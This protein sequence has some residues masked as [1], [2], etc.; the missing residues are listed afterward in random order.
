MIVHVAPGRR[1]GKSSF[2]KLSSYISD[3]IM[4]SGESP[5]KTSW[6]YLTQYITKE[7][8]L[9]ELGD[10][11]E[12]T[13]AVEIG[14]L[15]S[16]K[17]APHEMRAVAARNTRQ[18]DPV[19]H[20][21]L[22]WPEGERPAPE[23]IFAAARHSLKALGMQD[24]QYIVAIHANTDN[25]HAHIEVN[26]IH[27]KTFRAARLEWAHATLHKA[28]RESELTFGWQHDNGIYEV[29]DVNGTKHIV[30]STETLDPNLAPARG[31]ANR[32]ETWSGEQSLETWCKGAPAEELK[33]VLK[34]AKTSNWQ[35]VH[36]VLARHGLELR[37]S[38]GGGMKVYDVSEEQPGKAGKP[39]AVSASKAFRFLKR[40]ELEQRLGPFEA[41]AADL[42]LDE[43]QRT[44][45][46]DP[47][48]RLDR[49]LARKAQRDALHDR[50]KAAMN[51]VRVR[52]E[53]AS[54]ELAKR[55][56]GDD[57]ARL[58]A[59]DDQYRQQRAAIRGNT[60]LA[61][62]QKQ[63]A[64]M[65]AKL[66]MTKAREQLK[67]QIAVERAARR[68]LL[69][70]VPAWREWVE[71]QAQL[72]DESAISALRGL[73]YQEKRE[74]KKA[75]AVVEG[76][77]AILPASYQDTDPYVRAIQ[78]IVWKVA[79]N[80][81]VT[82]TFKNGEAGFVDEG[83]KL[84]FGRK[85]VSDEA[86]MVS[87]RYAADKWGGELHLSGGDAA[88]KARVARMAVEIG[89]DLK[90]PE[91]QELQRQIRSEFEHARQAQPAAVPGKGKKPREGGESVEMNLRLRDDKAEIQ[92]AV[93][94]AKSYSGRIVAEDH[95]YIAQHIGKNGY[96][97]HEKAAFKDGPPPVG[98]VASI[99]Y[100]SGS[101][102]VQTRVQRGRGGK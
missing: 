24:H 69:P 15:E 23:D 61:P 34:A 29:V 79:R 93:T 38:G 21:I 59:L 7:S 72:G 6:D 92:H 43:P 100:Q 35:D 3:G 22:S 26:R 13:I 16:L 76:E 49:R 36:R 84:T 14:N 44:Y 91:L 87:L 86:L 82:Y 97:L 65:L 64:Y 81:R 20:Y 90:N 33:T 85:E 19:Y 56:G 94:Q 88:F 30:R 27:P 47:Q 51:E 95:R 68:A 80:G 32:F 50:Y 77:N 83:A 60:A 55:F 102:T 57:Q 67:Q 71:Q 17:T 37:D 4:Q 58:K 8:V 78:N 18:K 53:I 41:K 31:A 101:A 10:D 74:G 66:T 46:R 89:V 42:D 63:Q 9:N 75:E 73:I 48:K 98:Q 45:K 62:A 1:D 96:V 28:A 70:A 52:R 99:R 40:G 25:L 11:V 12:K 2:E 5:L 39:L 54:Q